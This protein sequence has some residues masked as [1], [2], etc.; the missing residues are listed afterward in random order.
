MASFVPEQGLSPPLCGRSFPQQ[1][2]PSL[3]LDPSDFSL[4]SPPALPDQ[5]PAASYLAATTA[6]SYLC[7]GSQDQLPLPG[8]TGGLPAFGGFLPQ[9]YGLQGPV[10]GGHPGHGGSWFPL[11]SQDEL[12]R[13]VRPPYSYSA[14]IAMAIQGAPEQ[15][16]TLSQI[17][18]YVANNF[19]FYSRSKAGWQNSIRHNLS[20]N[21]CF[22]K[23]PRDE[24]DPGKG[25][26]WTLDPNCEKMFDNGNFRR[27]RKRKSDALVSD[28]DRKPSSCS[29]SSSGS[30][31]SSEPS[32]KNP[33]M[34]G[35]DELSPLSNSAPC[36][37]GF[38]SQAKE[39]AMEP[40]AG[41]PLPPVLDALPAPLSSL[42]DSQ[43]GSPPLYTNLQ[44]AHASSPPLY[45]SMEVPQRATPPQAHGS[46]FSPGAVTDS[47]LLYSSLPSSQ[48]DS[49]LLYATLQ[50]FQ[51]A[52]PPL[53]AQAEPLFSGCLGDSG[54]LDSLVLQQ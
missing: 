8:V 19:P 47:P 40:L 42:L 7:L 11:P 31:S 34:L 41:R 6:N 20:L 14:L 33:R 51:A 18:Q 12:M 44:T 32:P 30:E 48:A 9:F 37:S 36:L 15:R 2:L 28:S 35:G 39:M 25:N 1:E 38:L 5:A 29:S 24:S 53:Q 54:P 22:R 13:L 27:K 43:A 3:G 52:Q 45:P 46:S 17:Y 23:V 16:L 49:P 26:Y 50:T 4:Y 21:D 10:L